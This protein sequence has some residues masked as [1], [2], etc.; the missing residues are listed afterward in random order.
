MTKEV[1]WLSFPPDNCEICEA[2]IDALFYDA[3][4]VMGPWACMCHSCFALGPGLNKLGTGL[5]QK[6]Q[7][8]PTGKWLKT[9]G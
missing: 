7:K 4:T 1:Y 8:Q 9:G 2:E 3:A 6:Y 5:G